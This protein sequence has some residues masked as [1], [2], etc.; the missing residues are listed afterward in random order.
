MV[1][2]TIFGG[3]YSEFYGRRTREPAR[4][5]LTPQEF[6]ENFPFIHIAAKL[7]GYDFFSKEESPIPSPLLLK[8]DTHR[9]LALACALISLGL[10]GFVYPLKPPLSQTK[11]PWLLLQTLAA[12]FG[13][14]VGFVLRITWGF[15]QK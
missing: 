14:A 13:I 15:A 3:A 4:A 7:L 9:Q 6:K 1:W 8:R 2:L 11:M 12:C 10:M 5:N